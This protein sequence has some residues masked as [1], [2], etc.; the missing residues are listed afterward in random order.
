MPKDINI[1][2]KFG[3]YNISYKVLNDTIEL[4]RKHEQNAA[5]FPAIDYKELV[6]F[7]ESMYKADKARIVLIKKEG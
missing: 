5:T 1:L 6:I 2:N 4:L 7:F 3:N